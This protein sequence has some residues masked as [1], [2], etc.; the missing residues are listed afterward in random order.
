MKFPFALLAAFLSS[1]AASAAGE[2]L[3]PQTIPELRQ[4]IEMILAATRTPAAGI[5]L[6]GRDG[7]TWVAGIGLA[8]L[9]QK[10]P[11]TA[12]TAFPIGSIS[13]SFVG[14]SVLKLQQEGRLNL[15]DTLRSRAPE[16]DFNNPW[17]ATNPIRI[18]HLLEHTTGW[19]DNSPEEGSWNPMPNTTRREGLAHHPASRTSRWRP[20][21]SFS[22]SNLGPDVAAYVV[23]K[24]TGEGFEDYVARTWF[25]PLGMAD[26]SYAESSASRSNVAT[27]Y[28]SGGE[29]VQP[30]FNVLTRPAGAVMASPND[31]ANFVGFY[32]NRGSFRGRELLPDTAMKRMEHPTSTYAASEGIAIGYGLGNAASVWKGWIFH[33][34]GGAV[35]GALADMAYLPT[36]GV[37]YALMINSEN[38]DAMYQLEEVI[39][40]YLVRNLTAPLP[41]PQGGK[42][43][44]AQA[45]EYSGWYEPITPRS[46]KSKYLES[47]LGITHL[48]FENGN[49]FLRDLT[50]GKFAYARVGGRLYQRLNRSRSLVL[51]G[52]RSDGTLFQTIGG[53]TFRRMPAYVSFSKLGFVVATVLL[54]LSSAIFALFWLPRSL[55]GNLRGAPHLGVRS[56]P[57]L[58]TLLGGSVFV[59]IWEASGNYYARAGGALWSGDFVVI[60]DHLLQGAFAFFAIRGLLRALRRRR[61]Q[62]NRPVWWHAI[63][64]S[65]ILSVWAVYLAYWGLRSDFAF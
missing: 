20:G 3:G 29:T 65:F 39:R 50:N 19:D 24:V 59:L 42:A 47:M 1:I 27:G 55:F 53:P 38:E 52:D 46:E 56:D 44:E 33:G 41:P 51:V 28:R 36:E 32:L 48:N 30:H 35:P 21:T 8:D 34:H 9:A 22:Y 26:A 11:A 7:P 4:K 12:D 63:A 16:V 18:V 6:V 58:A 14:L 31:M 37:G 40:T 62:I 10:R 23:E 5:A 13:K 57:L 60:L 49:L 15:L 2:P 45:A 17:E 54:M 43:D 61:S 64:T 25:V